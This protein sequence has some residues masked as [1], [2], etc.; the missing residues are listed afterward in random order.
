M[1]VGEG[2]AD[3]RVGER[4]AIIPTHACTC[5]NLHPELLFFAGEETHWELVD[6]R[7]WRPARGGI[8]A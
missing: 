8:H 2:V 6:A 7:G 5:V 4:L 3:L 1:V